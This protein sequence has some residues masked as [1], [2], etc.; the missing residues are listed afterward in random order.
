[1]E[2]STEFFWLVES[3]LAGDVLKDVKET[4]MNMIVQDLDVNDFPASVKA[5]YHLCVLKKWFHS[6]ARSHRSVSDESM[7]VYFEIKGV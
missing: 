5:R 6:N 1:M 7:G 2:E 4:L 3:I